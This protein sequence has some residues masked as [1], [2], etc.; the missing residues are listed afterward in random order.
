M[1]SIIADGKRTII[2][3]EPLA[4]SLDAGRLNITPVCDSPNREFV[5]A[6]MLPRPHDTVLLV[7]AAD[8]EMTLNGVPVRGGIE[9]LRPSDRLMLAPGLDVTIEAVRRAQAREWAASDRPTRCPVCRVHFCEG[10]IVMLC[11]RC[12]TPHHNACYI[13]REQRCGMFGCLAKGEAFNREEIDG[14]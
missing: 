11:P 12:G 10:E 4:I 2:I 6:V 9:L 7:G 1:N 3:N 8:S 14:T 13:A 5:I